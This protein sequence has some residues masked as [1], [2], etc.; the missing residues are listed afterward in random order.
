MTSLK[1]KLITLCI[2]VALIFAACEKDTFTNNDAKDI[3]KNSQ[4]VT[5]NT[6][7]K[8]VKERPASDFQL[9]NTFK[10]TQKLRTARPD[11]QN[12]VLDG[13]IL[14]IDT[15]A[16]SELKRTAPNSLRL[17]VPTKD[18]DFELELV[19]ADIFTHDFKLTTIDGQKADFDLGVHYRG[20]I[21]GDNNSLVALSI[22]DGEISGFFSNDKGNYV[23]GK[24]TDKKSRKNEHIVY[25]ESDLTGEYHM[26]CGTE[27]M[28][29]PY[30]SDLLEYKGAEVQYKNT[31][32]GIRIYIEIDNDIFVAKGSSM[33]SFVSSIFNQSAALYANEGVNIKVSQMVYWP[34]A[35]SYSGR[36]ARDFLTQF[37]NRFNSDN[38]FGG[39]IGALVS[40]KIGGSGIAGSIGEYC[41]PDIDDRMFFSGIRSNHNTPEALNYTRSV[42][43]FAHELGH[44]LG[45]RHTHA[46]VWNG[47][48]TAID[49]CGSC[50]EEPNPTP[51]QSLDCNFCVR[52]AQPSGGGTIMSYCDKT[53][54]GISFSNGFGT[55]PGN[56]IRNTAAQMLN[57][58]DTWLYTRQFGWGYFQGDGLVYTN[59]YGWI[60]L[61]ED[62]GDVCGA[63]DVWFYIYDGACGYGA[64]W[65]KDGIYGTGRIYSQEAGGWISCTGSQGLA[66]GDD[67]GKISMEISETHQL[68]SSDDIMLNAPNFDE[69]TP[70]VEK[71][72]PNKTNITQ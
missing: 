53:S 48:N 25:F 38:A 13:T 1:I 36:S 67:T 62:N 44:V 30:P 56:V 66:A 6:I 60:Y 28:G 23:I 9:F 54:A 21:K 19:K 58:I 69:L 16:L 18:A 55:Q 57:G 64:G 49:G 2:S 27:D 61:W 4:T 22:Q 24:M 72:N 8:T 40:F 52:P 63:Q 20:I 33:V 29:V 15:K 17:A 46:C 12:L 39:H 45:S 68:E 65:Y 42:K 31:G 70:I 37:Q 35:S 50:Q 59:A 51:G 10:N 11:L 7:S 14:D 3:L 71:L 43:V 41:S 34:S 47:N 26:E 5:K 32:Q